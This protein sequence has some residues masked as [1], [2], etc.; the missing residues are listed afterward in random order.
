[1]INNDTSNLTIAMVLTRN[2]ENRWLR[3]Y[4]FFFICGVLILATQILLGVKFF[5]L[6]GENSNTN[7]FVPHKISSKVENKK[8]GLIIDDEDASNVYFQ[9]FS[10]Q[11]T[12]KTNNKTHLQLNELEFIP[13][14]EITG[15]EAISAIHR[16]KTQRCKQEIANVTCLIKKGLL[17]PKSLPSFCPN[18]DLESGKSLGCFKDEKN[19]RL[20]SG[21]YG[22]NKNDNSPE[23]CIR[24]CLQSGFVYAGV[25]YS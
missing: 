18:N 22:N 21:Y 3:R 24:L 25:Q 16:A 15:K 2:L 4:K 12:L 7:A 13:P 10:T 20:L 23:F 5:A 1:M 19:F 9:R 11:K 17:Y 14:C 6:N 8:S